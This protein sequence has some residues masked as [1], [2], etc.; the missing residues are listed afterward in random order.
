MLNGYLKDVIFPI[1]INFLLGAIDAL[2]YI[3]V[4]Y[5]YCTDHSYETREHS[6]LVDAIAMVFCI[7]L[8]GAGLERAVFVTKHKNGVYIPI[9]MMVVGATNNICWVMCT[10]LDHN[11]LMLGNCIMVTLLSITQLVLFIVYRSMVKISGEL[12]LHGTHTMH[13]DDESV[14]PIASIVPEDAGTRATR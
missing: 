3:A 4:H 9:Y 5:R 12:S 2:V 13:R 14:I 10:A 11:W 1:F 6:A 8:Y 7:K